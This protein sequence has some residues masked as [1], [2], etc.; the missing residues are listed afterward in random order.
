MNKFFQLTRKCHY[1]IKYNNSAKMN[2]RP[3]YHMPSSVFKGHDLLLEFN[4]F[5]VNIELRLAACFLFTWV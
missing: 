5:G 1:T 2:S 4:L 3:R